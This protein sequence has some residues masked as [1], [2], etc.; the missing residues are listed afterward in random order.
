MWCRGGDCELPLASTLGQPA[1]PAGRHQAPF[2]ISGTQQPHPARSAAFI[3]PTY[4]WGGRWL[5]CWCWVQSL[6]SG[7]MSC[8][9]PPPSCWGQ[10]LVGLAGEAASWG[11]RWTHGREAPSGKWLEAERGR[12]ARRSLWG[13]EGQ[14][15]VWRGGAWP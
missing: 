3:G 8:L 4:F 9:V 1:P 7:W 15:F 10:A 11:C 2:S 6:C 12:P 14:L 13:S 5:A